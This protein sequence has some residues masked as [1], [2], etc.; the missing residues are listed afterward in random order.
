MIAWCKN[1]D[2]ELGDD[3]LSDNCICGKMI[4]ENCWIAESCDDLYCEPCHYDT[5]TSPEEKLEDYKANQ[6]DQDRDEL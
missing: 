4:C 5:F 3:D 2:S 1:C 6:A